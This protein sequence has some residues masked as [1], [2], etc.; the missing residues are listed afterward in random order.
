MKKLF[1]VV[2]LIFVSISCKLKNPAEPEKELSKTWD[3][4]YTELSPSGGVY[5]IYYPSQLAWIAK[6]INEGNGLTNETIKLMNDIN[7]SGKKFPGIATSEGVKFMGIFD[8]NGYSVEGLN[9]DSDKN[10]V[11]FIGY[12]DTGA[13]VKN[14]NIIGTINAIGTGIVR[15]GGIAGINYG[16]ILNVTNNIVITATITEDYTGVATAYVGGIAGINNSL[17]FESANTANITGSVSGFTSAGSIGGIAGLMGLQG[18]ISKCYNSG[19]I[20]SEKDVEGIENAGGIVGSIFSK[21]EISISRTYNVGNVKTAKQNGFAGGIVGN[22]SGSGDV[23]IEDTYNTG[24]IDADLTTGGTAGGLVGYG[25]TTTTT[26]ERAYNIGD[27]NGK[28]NSS[29]ANNVTVNTPTVSVYY[30]ATVANPLTGALVITDFENGAN[31][32]D[33][34]FGDVWTMS[35][36][37]TT[38]QSP[39]RRP[40]LIGVGYYLPPLIDPPDDI[41]R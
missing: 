1:F 40:I 10:N 31:F 32:N 14:L 30:K 26:I 17:I 27:V 8:G 19:V 21:T 28:T 35:K 38:G 5:Q 12:L 37:T 34:S 24:N 23:K 13:V 7:L 36:K 25:T 2:L 16:K 3:G 9:I 11:G 29:T 39:D 15:V 22:N 4:S 18:S 6:N 20:L 41:P 33:F